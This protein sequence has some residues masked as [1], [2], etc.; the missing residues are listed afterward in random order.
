MDVFYRFLG[1]LLDLIH[2]D[3]G[4]IRTDGIDDDAS[5]A[6]DHDHGAVKVE[7]EAVNALGDLGKT[8]L[9]LRC[10]RGRGYRLQAQRS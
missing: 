9:R 6:R 3:L 8:G 5:I 4:G 2:Q 10:L 7:T 1:D